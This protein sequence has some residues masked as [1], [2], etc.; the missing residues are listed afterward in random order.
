MAELFKNKL[1]FNIAETASTN[2]Y[3]SKLP[4]DTPEGSVVYTLNQTQGRG[5]GL[6]RWES[7]PNKNLTFSILLRPRFLKAFEQFYLLKVIAIAVADFIS[8]YTDKVSIKWPNDIY[9]S[10][11]K[12]AGILIENSIDRDFIKQSVVGIGVNINQ[13]LFYSDAPD[14]V[15]LTQ[16]THQEYDI[17]QCLQTVLD[18]IEKQYSLLVARDFKSIDSKYMSLLFRFN[19][20][21]KY[22]AKGKIFTGTIVAVE[23]TGEL[24]IVDNEGTTRHFLF[25]E[26][27]FMV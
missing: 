24:I 21:A 11:K 9:V 6:N 10:E 20:L 3:F 8:I 15:S 18:G 23:P 2:D 4:G 12:I 13:K 7:E 26:V 22:F 5:L 1:V 25:K 17:E 27:S 14:P 16:V 19:V